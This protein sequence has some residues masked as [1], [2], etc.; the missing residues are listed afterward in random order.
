MELT[1]YPPHGAEVLI[2]SISNDLRGKPRAS[3]EPPPQLALIQEKPE[4][5]PR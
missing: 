1:S 4:P 5:E 2:V 3:P